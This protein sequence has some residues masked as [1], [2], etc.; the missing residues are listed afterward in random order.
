MYTIRGGKIRPQSF[1]NAAASSSN[2]WQP[3]WV[4]TVLLVHKTMLQHTHDACKACQR[5]QL[6]MARPCAVNRRLRYQGKIMELL[7]QVITV[8]RSE[9]LN[10]GPKYKW[11]QI[12][13]HVKY[14][15]P[16]KYFLKYR[17]KGYINKYLHCKISMV[18]QG[19]FCPV[20]GK[21][22]DYSESKWISSWN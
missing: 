5:L 21:P 7:P 4:L 22:E 1:W 19:T 20:P 11:I 2:N 17:S 9:L 6:G 15:V 14:Q 3:A 18:V 10:R 8:L 16:L 13:D 12:N